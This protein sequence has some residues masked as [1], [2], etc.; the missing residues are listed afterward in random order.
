MV[1][2]FT[3]QIGSVDE[4]VKGCDVGV[5]R[6]LLSSFVLHPIFNYTAITLVPRILN[7]SMAKDYRPISCCY[8]I[9]KKVFDFLSW[10]FVLGILE[11]LG[12]PAQFSQWII[13]CITG[14][15]FSISFNESLVGYFMDE[16]GISVLSKLL[17]VVAAKKV[18]Q[19]HPKCGII[20]FEVGVDCII[21]KFYEFSRLWLNATKSELFSSSMSGTQLKLI[22]EAIEFKIRTLPVR[23]LRVPMVPQKLS[24]KD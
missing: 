23:Y 20:G 3:N 11:S 7:P 17:N 21:D 2:F 18:F 19:F 8:V 4:G 10:S 22:H 9:Y 16:R 13:V 6:K 12:V 15:R 1:R 24:K 14:S 5:L